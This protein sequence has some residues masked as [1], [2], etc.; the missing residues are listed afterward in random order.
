MTICHYI[1]SHLIFPLLFFAACVHLR[2]YMWDKCTDCEIGGEEPL[3]GKWNGD[4][5]P[6]TYNAWLDLSGNPRGTEADIVE[7][8]T[9]ELS[10]GCI[11]LVYKKDTTNNLILCVSRACYYTYSK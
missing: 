6:A 9:S 11:Y 1:Q 10:C 2:R 5:C 7:T 3:D 4:L 8:S